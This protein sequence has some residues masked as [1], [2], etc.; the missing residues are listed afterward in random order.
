MDGGC[1]ELNSSVS[2]KTKAAAQV[3]PYQVKSMDTIPI[4]KSNHHTTS[5][6][7]FAFIDGGIQPPSS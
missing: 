2:R 7:N 1:I 3:A 4:T 6:L 5:S